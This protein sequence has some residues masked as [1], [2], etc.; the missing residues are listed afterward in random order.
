MRA[1]SPTRE[2]TAGLRRSAPKA[3]ACRGAAI[4]TRE[5]TGPRPP[6]AVRSTSSAP[7]V[8]G[9][10]P[11]WSMGGSSGPRRPFGTILFDGQVAQHG[12]LALL[13]VHKADARDERLDDV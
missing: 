11:A 4:S 7:P 12:D 5:G 3:P 13:I 2:S 1:R 10:P 8:H 6:A 9:G